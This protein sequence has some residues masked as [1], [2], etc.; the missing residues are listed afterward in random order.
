MNKAP[1]KLTNLC[2][3]GI[4][5]LAIVIVLGNIL[6]AP[7]Y[8]AIASSGIAL[9]QIIVVAIQIIKNAIS[10]FLALIVYAKVI[11]KRK[12]SIAPAIICT[13]AFAL[14]TPIVA[15]TG[16]SIINYALDFILGAGA[17][18]IYLS[19][20][21]TVSS[22]AVQQSCGTYSEVNGN[23]IRTEVAQGYSAP[24]QTPPADIEALRIS[25]LNA[26][27]PSL[28]APMTAVLCDPEQMV[29]TNNNGVYEIQGY[30]NSH[31]SYGAM[32]ATDFTAKANTINGIWTISNVTVGKKAAQG[33]AKSFVSNYIA[34]SIFVA[35]MGIIGYLILTMVIG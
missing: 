25:L 32:I 23:V 18:F 26:I 7:I 35:L 34:I 8:Q 21:K 17:G 13:A 4:F 9:T 14:I 5:A 12:I 3:I 24:Q 11:A 28:K 31:N 2:L 30:V 33:F 1:S 6:V 22:A 15:R 20:T 16:I 27:R 10:M 19:M 29:I